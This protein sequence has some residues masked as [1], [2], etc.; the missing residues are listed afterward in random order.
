M[1][2]ERWIQL[3]V[4]KDRLGDRV[5]EARQVASDLYDLEE[6]NL[7]GL[8]EE[9]K[10]QQVPELSTW[11]DRRGLYATIKRMKRIRNA[12]RCRMF[13]LEPQHPPLPRAGLRLVRAAS[14]PEQDQAGAREATSGRRHGCAST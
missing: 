11:A 7:W 4:L 14:N 12:I 2:D 9:E 1:T 3:G 6:N 5:L 10:Q 8:S 13:G